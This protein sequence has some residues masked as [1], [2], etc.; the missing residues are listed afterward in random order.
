MLVQDASVV[1]SIFAGMK[2]YGWKYYSLIYR[3]TKILQTGRKNTVYKTSER[4]CLYDI[5]LLTLEL[6]RWPLRPIIIALM[7]TQH[8]TN[9]LLKKNLTQ[10]ANYQNTPNKK[11]ITFS[12]VKSTPRV[13]VKPSINFVLAFFWKKLA[14]IVSVTRSPK[15]RV[16][17]PIFVTRRFGYQGSL[18]IYVFMVFDRPAAACRPTIFSYRTLVSRHIISNL[19]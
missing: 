2:S 5:L 6:L 11:L 15:G 12:I 16:C 13:S 19:K 3:C 9:I 8:N 10:V 17:Y 1:C 4:H 18:I 7:K 14:P